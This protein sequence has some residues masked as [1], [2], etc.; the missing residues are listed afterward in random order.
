M[1]VPLLQLID[2][3]E[4][5]FDFVQSVIRTAQLQVMRRKAAQHGKPDV[6]RGCPARDADGG[7]LLPVVGRQVIVA[8]IHEVIKILPHK[9]SL[10]PQKGAVTVRKLL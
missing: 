1:A 5:V 3:V 10:A 8:F 2:S 4:Y 6:G 9:R 7:L